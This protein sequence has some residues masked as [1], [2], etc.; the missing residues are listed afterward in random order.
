[1]LPTGTLRRAGG[2]SVTAL[3]GY[4]EGAWWIQDAA[5]SLP[6]RLFGRSQGR[7]S[8]TCAP[9]RAARPRSSPPPGALVTAI[10]RSTR[11]LDRLVANLNRLDLPV[12]AIGADAL[13]WR[14][15]ATGRGRAARRAVHRDRRDPA[16]PGRAASESAGGCRAARR[17]C[18]TICCAPRSICC[19]R[20]A[21]WSIAPARSNPRRDRSGSS[22]CCARARRSSGGRSRPRDRR[23]AD[24]ITQKRRPA[25][26]AV[27]S[28]RT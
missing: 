21:R 4:A 14:P 22:R 18:R 5:A 25:H 13:T 24:W 23:A 19:S 26:A 27:P 10:D 9:R 6:A 2:G 20:A 16:P 8:S 7:E 17:W 1:M 28:R 3:P 12:T 15:T 11:R